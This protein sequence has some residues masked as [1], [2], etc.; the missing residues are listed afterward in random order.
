MDIVFGPNCKNKVFPRYYKL[1]VMALA[2]FQMVVAIKK[3]GSG[4]I[5]AF[6][7]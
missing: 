3:I 4:Y 7:A 2:M 1:W 5:W 6:N